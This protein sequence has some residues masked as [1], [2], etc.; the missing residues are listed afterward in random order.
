MLQ[1]QQ[2]TRLDFY[3]QF[4]FYFETMAFP[5]WDNIPQLLHESD[6]PGTVPDLEQTSSRSILPA[7]LLDRH[8]RYLIVCVCGGWGHACACSYSTYV[9]VQN[10]GV[11]RTTFPPEILREIRS[12]PLPASGGRQHSSACVP[13]RSNLCFC[14]HIAFSPLCASVKSPPAFLF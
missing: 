7:T 10:E 3:L 2:E 12:W 9:C 11:G 1:Q 6:V 5:Y 4:E 8:H 13:H 14:L